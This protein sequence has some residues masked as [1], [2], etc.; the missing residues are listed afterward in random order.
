M[1]KT[2]LTILIAV[3]VAFG[4]VVLAAPT[5]IFQRTILPEVTDTYDLG[6]AAKRWQ[7]LFVKN[8]TAA[9]CT[10]C[11]ATGTAF[12]T[13]TAKQ[14]GIFKD[15]NSLTGD[16]SFT[17]DTS[18]GLT[19]TVSST[20]RTTT[21]QYLLGKNGSTNFLTATSGRFTYGDLAYD[22]GIGRF[23]VV[24]RPTALN[25]FGGAFVVIEESLAGFT[26]S[27]FGTFMLLNNAG[28]SSASQDG[29]YQLNQMVSSLSDHLAGVNN[30]M[31]IANGSAP[32]G[33]GVYTQFALEDGHVEDAYGEFIDSANLE[34]LGTGSATRSH[35]IVVMP[36]G[37][38]TTRFGIQSLGGLNQFSSSTIFGTN[39][40][41]L[42]SYTV[43]VRGTL[44]ASQTSTLAT[45]TVSGRLGIGSVAP[46]TQLYVVKS[47]NTNAD[48]IQA[49]AN[50]LTAGIGMTYNSIRAIGTNGTNSLL[51]DGQT[52][53]NVLMQTVGTGNVGITTTTPA[54]TL[55]VGG[56][57]VVSGATSLNGALTLNGNINP[58]TDLTYTLGTST[59]RWISVAAPII[60][61]GASALT[62]KSGAAVNTVGGI[63]LNAS[64]TYTGGFPV[65]FQ[66]GGV[67]FF[68]FYADGSSGTELQ[69]LNGAGSM[70]GGLSMDS[71]GGLFVDT[72][73]KFYPYTRRG[74][75][76]GDATHEFG[77]LF[78]GMTS[79]LASTTISGY[80]GIGTTNPTSQLHI[81]GPGSS[82]MNV[83]STNNYP[84]LS[85][86]APVGFYPVQRFNLNGAAQW[87]TEGGTNY[88]LYSWGASKYV[89]SAL[90]ASGY[91]GINSTSPATQFAVT[92]TST[93]TNISSAANQMLLTSN[94]ADSA[95]ASFLISN[96]N[97]TDTNPVLQVNGQVGALMAVTRNVFSPVVGQGIVSVKGIAFGSGTSNAG[98]LTASGVNGLYISNNGGAA[99]IQAGMG[100]GANMYF[101]PVTDET[102]FLGASTSRW[103]TVGGET[104][105]SGVAQMSFLSTKAAN[106][107]PSF[108]WNPINEV[109]S[110]YQYSFQNGGKDF[111][112]IFAN[113]DTG[114]EVPQLSF[115]NSGTGVFKGG[116]VGYN[117]RLTVYNFSS[118]SPDSHNAVNLGD[119]THYWAQFYAVSS[120]SGVMQVTS[121]LT[122]AGT[123]VK[124]ALVGTTGSIGGSLLAAGACSSATTTVTG[125][126]TAM[127]VTASPAGGVDPTNGGILGV[128]IDPL[129][130]ATDTVKVSVCSP[131]VGTPTAA[132]YNVRVIQ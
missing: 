36:Q 123:A 7:N 17:F 114:G 99:V 27:Q 88:N 77:N 42:P 83:A 60:D 46:A 6:S 55:G 62:L 63:T 87:Q 18:T 19:N 115:F 56:T 37:F 131:I 34:F 43:D 15:S 30:A 82:Q 67:D 48:I 71:G 101:S 121:T 79:T 81:S 24:D 5:T 75:D 112:K 26:G 80:L 98:A 53:G 127:A 119:A 40:S 68:R 61:S 9:G 97:Y 72:F 23:A 44:S 89:F 65:R 14:V 118:F 73:N 100:T 45:T 47:D 74:V 3:G 111:L 106:A 64:N 96:P 38:G 49:L 128:S 35:G 108:L 57:L 66:N 116:L 86:S 10:G 12:A 21:L 102:G 2:I 113:P 122:V 125:A 110:Q 130:T 93:L 94:L 29:I 31:D 13:G 16:A 39:S 52:S 78:V 85:I 70:V 54:G 4:T 1:R 76:L 11:S 20:F 104:F 41:T 105:H 117:T 58:T 22:L 107:T 32:W 8:L 25:A 132:N 126:T 124:G 95:T 50:N 129:I 51:I 90:G 84:I 28:G 33:A 120:T 91:V 59:K 69:W 103:A 109:N 92:G